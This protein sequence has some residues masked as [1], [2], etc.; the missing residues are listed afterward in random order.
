MDTS[1]SLYM[2]TKWEAQLQQDISHE[3]WIS[4][5]TE[6]HKVTNSTS[7]RE[8]KWK[9]ISRFFKTPL[10]TAKAGTIPTSECWRKCGKQTGNHTRI[11]WTY[12]KLTQS[13]EVFK[14]INKIFEMEIP[15]D[16]KT[17]ILG[18]IPEGIKSRKDPSTG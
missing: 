3:E 8:Y 7:W 18:F 15:Q 17:A 9:V 13:G 11:I 14:D 6:A 12:P 2:K 10:L 1:D 16:F 4:A 5:C